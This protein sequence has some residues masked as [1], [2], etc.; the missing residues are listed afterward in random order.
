MHASTAE[1]H[2]RQAEQAHGPVHTQDERSE[3]EAHLLGEALLVIIP[4]AIALTWAFWSGSVWALEKEHKLALLLISIIFLAHRCIDRLWS[5][6]Q[7]QPH[8]R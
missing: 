5:G 1:V 4:A 2:Q 3:S 8:E 7:A 6:G